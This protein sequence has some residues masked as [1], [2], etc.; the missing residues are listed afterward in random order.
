MD[1]FWVWKNGRISEG[2]DELDDVPK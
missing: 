1:S 2:R